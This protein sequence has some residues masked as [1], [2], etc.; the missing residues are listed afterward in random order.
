M[1]EMILESSFYTRSLATQCRNLF[2]A[3]GLIGL[4]LTTTALVVSYRM[5]SADKPNEFIAHV[6]LTVL[7]FFLTGDFWTVGLLYRDLR[8]AADESHREA[9][10]LLKAGNIT[11]GAA[12]EVALDY[13]TAVVQAPPLLSYRYLKTRDATDEVFVRNY[14][15][16]LELTEETGISAH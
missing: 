16:L 2:F 7:I 9:Y 3:I 8:Q 12:L 10:V 13:N 11:D 4:A 1:V 6:V 15:K 5:R 14:G